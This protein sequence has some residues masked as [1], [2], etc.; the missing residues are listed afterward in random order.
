MSLGR[1]APTSTVPAMLLNGR[2]LADEA[3]L[4]QPGLKVLYATGYTRNAIIHQ[5]RLV[6]ESA[7][8][9]LR[10]GSESLEALSRPGSAPT[11]LQD[12]RGP[13]L[14]PAD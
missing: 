11:R 14:P 7:M 4:R 6:V 1:W 12:R 10:S 2:Q 3:R 5:G 8:S 13:K 9:D